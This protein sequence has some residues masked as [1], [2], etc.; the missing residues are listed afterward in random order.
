MDQA[1]FYGPFQACVPMNLYTYRCGLCTHRSYGCKVYY[2]VLSFI[3]EQIK[4][5]PH[6]TATDAFGIE[7]EQGWHVLPQSCAPVC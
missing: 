3:L 2:L 7:E 5:D 1:V 4:S 6:K